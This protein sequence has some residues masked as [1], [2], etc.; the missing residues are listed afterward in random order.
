[1]P[2]SPTS[3]SNQHKGNRSNDSYYK[4]VHLSKVKAELL[5]LTLETNRPGYI[6]QVYECTWT[7]DKEAGKIGPVHYHVGKK[8]KL[9]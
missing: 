5:K 3:Y 2:R 4:M 7:D 8:R 9:E 6:Y 1:M